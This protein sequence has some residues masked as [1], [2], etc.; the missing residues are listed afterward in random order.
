MY[1]TNHG[2]MP[3]INLQEKLEMDNVYEMN[4]YESR[5]DYLNNLAENMGVRPEV[6]FALADILGE[7]EDFDGLV[8]ALD[9]AT[10]LGDDDWY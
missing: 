5:Q 10:N 6:V 2:H 7:T 3:V 4:G 8:T 1:N 9:D